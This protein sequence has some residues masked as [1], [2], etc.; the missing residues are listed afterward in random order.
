[1]S[2]VCTEEVANPWDG[3]AQPCNAPAVSYRIDPNWPTD[4]PYPVCVQHDRG[5]YPDDQ[6][7]LLADLQEHGYPQ[8]T[9]QEER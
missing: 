3:Q 4:D 1:M 7:R 2:E 9:K 6:A 8:E 5:P